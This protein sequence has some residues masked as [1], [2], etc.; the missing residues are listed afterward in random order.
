MKWF[1]RERGVIVLGTGLG[2]LIAGTLLVKNHHPV[3]I[4]KEKGYHPIYSSNG[5]QFSPFSNFSEKW[6]TP[7]LLKRISF[8]LD[9]PHLKK[10]QNE[11]NRFESEDQASFQVILPKSRIDLFARPSLLREE[12][13][14]EFP[15][16]IEKV[17]AFYHEL[18]RYKNHFPTE[19]RFGE[20]HLIKKLC[21]LVPISKDRLDRKLSFFSKEFKTFILLQ[22]ISWGNLYSES[23]PLSLVATILFNLMGGQNSSYQLEDLEREILGQFLSWGGKIEEIREIKEIRREWRRGITLLG[24]DQREFQSDTLIVN[25]PLHQGFPFIRKKGGRQIKWK[26]KISPLYVV[27]PLFLGIQ[28]KV[29]PVGM[30]DHLISLLDIE[31]PFQDGNLLLLSLS[32]QGDK[33]HAPDR[34]R[35]LTVVGWMESR[36]GDPSRYFNYQKKVMEHLY[37][38]IPFLEDYIELI[39]LRWA[40]EQ[41][42][43]W[44]Y[45]HY[46]YQSH[47]D[48][49]WE[50]GMA[51]LKISRGIYFTG[52]E[53]FP[54]L[55]I[56]GEI[57]S[58]ILVAQQILKKY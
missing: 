47:I 13:S 40:M 45:P 10:I 55:G 37:H 9:L 3:L 25:I 8:D 20:K 16:E 4:L 15:Y 51:P 42:H 27:V 54:Y 6:L 39:D 41:V 31:K 5:Y 1:V 28:E 50:Y 18:E 30:K 58:G 38:L 57:L 12:W 32:P 26:S 23:Y 21:S 49:H 34:R 44:S 33:T 24:E 29:I 48:S 43:K 19:S 17:E 52:R 46:L 14:R 11:R 7:N 36:D 22:L 35:A 2:G 53:T 56:E